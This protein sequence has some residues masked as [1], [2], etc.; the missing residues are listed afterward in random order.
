MALL[1][2]KPWITLTEANVKRVP[3]T[4]G[5]FQIGD[6]DG[7]VIDIDYAGGRT[8]FGLRGVLIDRIRLYSPGTGFRVEIHSQY[9]SRFYELLMLY[10][11]QHGEL[12]AAVT[13]RGV[14]VPGRLYPTGFT[15]S[16]D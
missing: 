12:P 15:R 9:L 11:A 7:H 10:R 6:E 8:T 5:V 14:R 16:P 2:G 4:T 13:E 3:A 1:P